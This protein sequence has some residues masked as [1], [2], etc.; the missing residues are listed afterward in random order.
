MTPNDKMTPTQQR[1][2]PTQSKPRSK[3]AT[4]IMVVVALLVVLFGFIIW[5]FA[6]S[7]GAER[8]EVSTLNNQPP[9]TAEPVAPIPGPVSPEPEAPSSPGKPGAGFQQ[10]GTAP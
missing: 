7:K 9:G 1:L 6:Y 10:P 3:R 4:L 2:D 8:N 5:Y